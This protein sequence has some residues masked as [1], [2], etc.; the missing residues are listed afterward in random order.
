ME[1][2]AIQVLYYEACPSHPLAFED[3]Q[4]IVAEEG[5]EATITSVSVE[6]EAQAARLRFVGSPTILVNGQ[7][8]DPPSEGTPYRLTCR[9][10]QLEDGRVSPLPSDTM[11]RT[12][13]REAEK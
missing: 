1:T 13:L 9:V 11:I 4:R 2:V 8:I 10:Y 3:L 5:I 6:T 12:A 7:D